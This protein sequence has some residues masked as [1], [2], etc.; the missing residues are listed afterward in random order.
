MFYESNSNHKG[1]NY[2]KIRKIDEEYDSIFIKDKFDE[3]SICWG[4]GSN[5]SIKSI[6]MFGV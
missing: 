5:N 4:L 6:F 1:K 2:I 3:S